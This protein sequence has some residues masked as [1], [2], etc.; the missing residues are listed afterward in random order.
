[1]VNKVLKLA[2]SWIGKNEKDGSFKEIIDIYNT[3]KPLP[4]GYKVKYTD[5][6]CAT[7]VSALAVKLGITDIMFTE[8]SCQKMI[9]KYKAIGR[10]QEDESITPKAGY[11]IFYDWQ[12][13]GRGD[14]TGWADHT[15]IVESVSNGKITII[16]GNYNSR[17][18]RRTLEVNATKIRGYAMPKYETEAKVEVK[19]TNIVSTSNSVYYPKY[20]G[21]SSSL[22]TILEAIG[23][24]AIYRGHWT[25]RKPLAA[26][27]GIED[28]SGSATDNS[29]LKALARNGKLK[30][31]GSVVK[32]M[33]YDKYTGKS[34]KIDEVFR[35]IGVETKFIGNAAKRKPVAMA[36]GILAT[37]KGSYADNVTLINLAK[38]GKLKRV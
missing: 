6:W 16:E 19:P 29:T 14:N 31:V 30:V 8:C 24:S 27:N 1:M 36:N 28:Y 23:V 9:D 2:Q 10:W 22:D 25:K 5:E 18:A 15:G 33:Y 38:N 12:D 7:T 37:Y 17:V 20:T 13:N 32:P 3:Q 11:I 26:A 34:H 21:T 35:A 4:R